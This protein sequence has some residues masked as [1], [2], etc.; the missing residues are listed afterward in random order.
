MSGNRS[1]FTL[2]SCACFVLGIIILLVNIIALYFI[3]DFAVLSYLTREFAKNNYVET[4]S[5]HIQTENDDKLVLVYGKISTDQILADTDFNVKVENSTN[6][7]R[8]VEMYQW[9]ETF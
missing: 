1:G 2:A 7:S 8:I 6:F 4:A 3:E 5:D 9:K